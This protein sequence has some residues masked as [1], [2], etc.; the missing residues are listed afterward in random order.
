[1]TVGW[2]HNFRGRHHSN[3]RRR[4]DFLGRYFLLLRGG[5]TT[6]KGGGAFSEGGI[7]HSEDSFLNI[8]GDMS[9]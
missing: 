9:H 7:M 1:M 3:G 8:Q 2:Q 4:D 6:L 5:T